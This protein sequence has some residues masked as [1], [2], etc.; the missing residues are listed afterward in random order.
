MCNRLEKE[1]EYE[2]CQSPLNLGIKKTK[3]LERSGNLGKVWRM[4]S[5][6]F[7]LPMEDLPYPKRKVSKQ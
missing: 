6:S 4:K 7:L 2:M 3:G 5:P 1:G